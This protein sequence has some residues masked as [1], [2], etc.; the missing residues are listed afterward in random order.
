MPLRDLTTPCALVD[1]AVVERNTA[2]MADRA[3]AAGVALRPHVKTHKCAEAAALQVAGHSGAVTASTLGEAVWFGERGFGDVTLAVPIAPARA[4]DAVA[5]GRRME[6]LGLLVD[7]G[8]A[9][10]AIEAATGGGGEGGD[11]PPVPV[12]LKV[13]CGYGRAGVAPDSDEGLALARRLDDSPAIDFE[14]VLAHAGHSYDC[15]SV[16]AVVAVA[17]QER[18]V[19]AAFA[20]RLRAAGIAVRTV[21]A[22]STPTAVHGRDWTGVTELRPGNYAFFDAFQTAIGSCRLEDCAMTVLTTV[23]GVHPARDQVVVDAGALALSKDAGPRHVDPDCGYGVVLDLDRSPLP[24]TVASLSQEHG[25]LRVRDPAF[26]S[27][28]RVGDRLRIVPHHSC[29]AAAL[30]D[31]YVVLDGGGPV[32][33]WRRAPLR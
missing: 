21:S 31:E 11:G 24:L 25:Q 5:A 13:D 2:A 30:Y 18:S 33:R 4:A 10:D 27:R 6:R 28:V 22:G 17:E 12:L 20:D 3:T 29:L 7:S 14:G 26:F 15:A 23:I 32:D 8:E 16:D 1:R 19:T 9:I